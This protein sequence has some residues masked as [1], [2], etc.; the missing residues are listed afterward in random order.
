MNKLEE[1]HDEMFADGAI[2]E[3][4][5]YEGFET[6]HYGQLALIIHKVLEPAGGDGAHDG[7]YSVVIGE[8]QHIYNECYFKP[9]NDENT[10]E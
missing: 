10:D 1:T 9:L 7:L 8:K 4:T 2:V 6:S 5:A 3:I